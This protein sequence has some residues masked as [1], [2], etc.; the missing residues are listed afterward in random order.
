M[1]KHPP[2]TPDALT[3]ALLRQ[4]RAAGGQPPAAAPPSATDSPA[5]RDVTVSDMNREKQSLGWMRQF[6]RRLT[7]RTPG[8][9]SR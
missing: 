7:G 6:G 9:Q 1:T 3:E 8:E 2:H 4:Q 5:A